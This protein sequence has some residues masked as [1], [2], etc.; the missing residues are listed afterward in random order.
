MPNVVNL[1]EQPWLSRHETLYYLRPI[2]LFIPFHPLCYAMR[3]RHCRKDCPVHLHYETPGT[4]CTRHIKF[5]FG[6]VSQQNPNQ[7]VLSKLLIACIGPRGKIISRHHVIPVKSALTVIMQLNW[8]YMVVRTWGK[9]CRGWRHHRERGNI[10]VWSAHLSWQ[11]YCDVWFK[12]S[13]CLSTN[14]FF[15]VSISLR[16]IRTFKLLFIRSVMTN[17]F[18][19]N[20]CLRWAI[21]IIGIPMDRC[22]P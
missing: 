10:K 4:L 13:C 19:H 5:L 21:I 6:T 3:C 7:V 14:Y 15:R 9:G 11:H 12:V 20:C 17:I 1:L 22:Y 8:T 2:S 16:E 18:C